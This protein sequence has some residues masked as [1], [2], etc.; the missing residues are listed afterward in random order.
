MTKI[1]F[2][3]AKTHLSKYARLAEQ[4]E[5]ILVVKHRKPSFVITPAGTKCDPSEKK[6]G[7]LKGKIRLA[8]DFDQTPDSV[9]ESFYAD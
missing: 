4:G 6:L 9:V 1:S 8:P 5:S 7:M 3:E 2:S